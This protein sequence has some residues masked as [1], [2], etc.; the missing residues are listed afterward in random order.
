MTMHRS[1]KFIERLI[2]VFG[3]VKN[4]SVFKGTNIYYFIDNVF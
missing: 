4:M 1:E 3:F 2:Q